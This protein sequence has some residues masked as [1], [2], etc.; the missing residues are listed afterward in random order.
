MTAKPRKHPRKKSHPILLS[1]LAIACSVAVFFSPYGL[2]LMAIR[3]DEEVADSLG[4]TPFTTKLGILVI[5]GGFLSWACAQ[6]GT[7]EAATRRDKRKRIGIRH[8]S[9]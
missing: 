7:H 9:N 4:V 8:T 5:S 6:E 1:V 2:R 3:D